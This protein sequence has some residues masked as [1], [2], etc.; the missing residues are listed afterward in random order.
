MFTVEEKAKKET[1]VKQV[2]SRIVG[3][4]NGSNSVRFTLMSSVTLCSETPVDFQGATCREMQL[5]FA[6]S[7]NAGDPTLTDGFRHSVSHTPGF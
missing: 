4:H 7:A 5:V 3:Y 1:S 2:P 6:F